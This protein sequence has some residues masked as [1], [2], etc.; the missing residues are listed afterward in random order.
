MIEVAANLRRCPQCRVTYKANTVNFYVRRNVK[1]GLSCYCKPCEKKNTQRSR[2]V[3]RVKARV[4]K[5]KKPVKQCV[6]CRK[7]LVG[8]MN[9]STRASQQEMVF[10]LGVR[11]V[12]R[13][14]IFNGERI[15]R[16]KQVG[17]SRNIIRS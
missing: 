5:R 10:N 17:I 15:T 8:L 2:V 13:T 9:S 4:L 12:I 14:R 11:N 1:G 3:K 7:T 6:D 16:F